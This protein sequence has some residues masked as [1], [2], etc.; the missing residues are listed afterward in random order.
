MKIAELP[1]KKVARLTLETTAFPPA[2]RQVGLY[3]VLKITLY[4]IVIV[5]AVLSQWN[6]V[7]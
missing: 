4:Y 2:F 5:K 1:W 6:R 7:A 3:L